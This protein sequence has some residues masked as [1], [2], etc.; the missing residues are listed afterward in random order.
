MP[1]TSKKLPEHLEI[2]L[3]IQQFAFRKGTWDLTQVAS[4]SPGVVQKITK[5]VTQIS[6]GFLKIKK[7]LDACQ[8]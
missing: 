8:N 4:T 7:Y 2:L 3:T 6:L 5:T 1:I